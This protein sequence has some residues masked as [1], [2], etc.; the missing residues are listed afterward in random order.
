MEPSSRTP[1]GQ[2][3][4]CPLCGKEVYLEPSVPPGDAPCPHC[5]HLLWFANPRMDEGVPATEWPSHRFARLWPT[6]PEGSATRRKRRHSDYSRQLHRSLPA[7]LAAAAAVG[8]VVG[9]LGIVGRIGCDDVALLPLCACSVVATIVVSMIA[10]LGLSLSDT[11]HQRLAEGRPVN[12]ILR[13]YF[14]SSLVSI[15]LWVGTTIVLAFLVAILTGIW[16]TCG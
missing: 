13:L 8:F 10:A 11:L 12:T 4:R 6:V 14:A 15:A 3:N 1:E 9:L 16:M 5:G 7:T 2:P